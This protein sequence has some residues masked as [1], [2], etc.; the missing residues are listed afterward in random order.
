MILYVL[1]KYAISN[2]K[3]QFHLMEDHTCLNYVNKL[4][5][6][7]GTLQFA[8]CMPRQRKQ[9]KSTIALHRQISHST[10]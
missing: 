5:Q 2:V 8:R 6:I 7:I 10:L 3:V 4:S 1:Q 9:Q